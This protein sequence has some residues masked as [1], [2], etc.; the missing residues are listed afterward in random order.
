MVKKTV[1]K[2]V[3]QTKSKMQSLKCPKGFTNKSSTA[4]TAKSGSIKCKSG[5]GTIIVMVDNDK[6]KKHGYMPISGA[7]TEEQ[8]QSAMKKAILADGVLPVF[9]RVNYLAVVNKSNPEN[10]RVFIADKTWIKAHYEI[11]ATSSRKFK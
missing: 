10:E 7:Q 11:S 1:K 9:R 5:R 6:L 2:T 8:R 3:K 4:E